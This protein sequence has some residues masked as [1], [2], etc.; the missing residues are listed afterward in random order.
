MC[1]VIQL[2][3]NM[4]DLGKR[5]RAT[6]DNP[7]S[8]IFRDEVIGFAFKP[9]AVITNDKPNIISTDVHWGLIPSWS[10]DQNIRKLTLNAKIETLD[11][12]PSFKNVVSNRC[13]VIATAYFEWHWN[14]PKG[15]SK[16]KYE[17]HSSENEIFS[18]AGIFSHWQNRE[19]GEV[20]KTF[21]IITTE[22]N[23]EMC[24]VHNTK[25]R[26]PVML[27]QSDEAAWLDAKNPIDDFKY[28]LY[29]ASVIAFPV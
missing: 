11:E 5:F 24:Y 15:K 18:L 29:N 4:S 26:M 13:L 17:I 8:D 22:A 25:R 14:D 16:Q 21:S 10:N 12:K 3:T 19:S 9:S 6:I 27:R 2:K 7:E 28:P 23:P 1:N 20:V